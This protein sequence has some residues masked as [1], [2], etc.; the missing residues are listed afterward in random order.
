MLEDSK[1]GVATVRPWHDVICFSN[2]PKNR[3]NVGPTFEAQYIRPAVQLDTY[4]ITAFR[5]WDFKCKTLIKAL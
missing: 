4:R 3:E 2:T 1:R 5:E